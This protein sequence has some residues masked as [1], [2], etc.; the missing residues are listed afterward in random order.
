MAHRRRIR[1]AC[2][3]EQRL[4]N[5]SVSVQRQGTNARE[6][7]LHRLKTPRPGIAGVIDISLQHSKRRDFSRRPLV[8]NGTGESRHE[9]KLHPRQD[10]AD[11]E[12]WIDPLFKASIE[13]QND[14][15]IV[16]YRRIAL[17]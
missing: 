11:L 2:Q 13:F 7:F 14:M 6:E 12:V 1:L 5:R 8:L 4:I 16:D 17:L 3:L 10:T 9:R 15:A